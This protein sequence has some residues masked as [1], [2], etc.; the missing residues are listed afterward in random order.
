MSYKYVPP[1]DIEGIRKVRWD[2][3][4]HVMYENKSGKTWDRVDKR[5]AMNVLR[6]LECS[7]K[8]G[9]LVEL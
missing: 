9:I 3:L 8:K 7:K 4:W 1:E 5:T 2:G 6:Q